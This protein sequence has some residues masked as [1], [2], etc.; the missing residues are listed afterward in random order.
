MKYFEHAQPAL[1]FLVPGCTFTVLIRALLNG[2]F[3][4][5]WK[6][7]ETHNRKKP[8]ENIENKEN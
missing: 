4:E 6:Y 1:L 3:K 5:L 2:E 8:I 7:E